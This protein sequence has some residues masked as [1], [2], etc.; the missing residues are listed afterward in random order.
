MSELKVAY[1]QECDLCHKEI[2]TDTLG[3]RRLSIPYTTEQSIWLCFAN[4]RVFSN[5]IKR[6][7]RVMTNCI[8]FDVK[9]SNMGVLKDFT[10]KWKED[11]KV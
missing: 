6:L 8:D 11:A 3:L 2:K 4:L 9:S 1:T 5:C 7:W 10:V